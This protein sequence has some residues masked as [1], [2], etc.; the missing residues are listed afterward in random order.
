MNPSTPYEEKLERYLDGLMT[1]QEAAELLQSIDADE[2]ERVKALQGQIDASL[3]NYVQVTPLDEEALAAKFMDSNSGQVAD[4]AS[5]TGKEDRGVFGRRS[6]IRI[7]VAASALLLASLAVRSYVGGVNIV[8][9]I[10]PI[11][12]LAAVYQE[13][14]DRGF[15]PYY[16]CEEEERFANFFDFNLGQ[17]MALAQMPA[18]SRMLGLS[19]LGGISRHTIAMLCEVDDSKV[20]VFVDKSGSSGLETAIANESSDLSVF[21]EKKNGFVFCEVTPL[22][23]SKMIEHFRFVDD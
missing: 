8:E 11:R 15:K 7:A 21:V 10:D 23:S 6:L 22:K 13:S 4:T 2:L 20:I 14:V 3:K 1:D 17:P 19:R 5:V 9:P 18:G 12:S 16:D